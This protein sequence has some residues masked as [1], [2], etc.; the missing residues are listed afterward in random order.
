MWMEEEAR[1]RR[2]GSY[3]EQAG[4]LA[5]VGWREVVTLGREGVWS[6][7]WCACCCCCQTMA[8]DGVQMLKFLSKLQKA[9]V[10]RDA[11]IEDKTGR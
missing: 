3:V 8:V 5:S 10:L 4:L 2:E 6:L 7:V 1:V 11:G 9:H